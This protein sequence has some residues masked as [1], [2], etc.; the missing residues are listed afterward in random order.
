ML[1]DLDAL[2]ALDLATGEF[3]RY[4]G[5]VTAGQLALPTPCDEW[6]VHYLIAHVVGGNRFAAHVLD[7]R[8]SSEAIELIMS[9]AQLG[10]RPGDDF[11]STAAEQR[12]RFRADGGLQRSVD[13]PLGR[14]STRR[15]LGLRIFDC[16]LHAW[17]LAVATGAD[18]ALDPALVEAV[19]RIM[20]S[21]PAGI[22]F[23]LE[24]TAASDGTPQ[25]QML[26][27]AGRA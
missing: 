19:L 25:Q 13:H 9:T 1:D 2:D 3:G 24:P 26:A 22:G 14:I 18:T 11:A 23:G 4:L 8:S 21:E 5:G 20:R 7:G 17:D 27:L 15:F 6:D 12:R 10:D 16:T